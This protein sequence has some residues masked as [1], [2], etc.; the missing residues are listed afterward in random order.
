METTLVVK[1]AVKVSAVGDSA[2]ELIRNASLNAIQA[3]DKGLEV[4][5]PGPWH[6]IDGVVVSTEG[7]EVCVNREVLEAYFNA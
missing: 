1:V 5:A 4:L 3:V 7:A 2:Q 6:H